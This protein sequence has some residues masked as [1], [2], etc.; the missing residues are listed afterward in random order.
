LPFGGVSRRICSSIQS[1]TRITHH[2]HQMK[3][4]RNFLYSQKILERE[5]VRSW[6]DS[7]WERISQDL[8]AFLSVV[9]EFNGVCAF[10]GRRRYRR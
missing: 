1:R 5:R 10:S 2:R 3:L 4:A 9:S 6:F 7:T 8:T